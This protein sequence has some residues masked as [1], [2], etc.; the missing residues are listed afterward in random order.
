MGSTADGWGRLVTVWM[1]GG[2]IKDFNTDPRFVD[3]LQR[4]AVSP[5]EKE[6]THTHTNNETIIATSKGY[7]YAYIRDALDKLVHTR[8]YICITYLPQA[9]SLG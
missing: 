4:Y 9:Y 1:A 6:K 5:G 8:P 3:A 7:T 2:K